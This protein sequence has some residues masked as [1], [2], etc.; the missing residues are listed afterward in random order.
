MYE[1]SD[2]T[3]WPIV[4]GQHY[5]TCCLINL[6]DFILKQ[7]FIHNIVFAIL[8]KILIFLQNVPGKINGM[9]F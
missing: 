1:P 8:K 9:P 3:L 5:L 4:A 2:L 7:F 6:V